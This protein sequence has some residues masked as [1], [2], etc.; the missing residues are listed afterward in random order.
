MV[1]QLLPPLTLQPVGAEGTV[2]S[3]PSASASDAVGEKEED[4]TLQEAYEGLL[5][6]FLGAVVPQLSFCPESPCQKDPGGA[7]SHLAACL[8]VVAPLDQE[9]EKPCGSPY[10]WEVLGEVADLRL[11]RVLL[12]H[13]QNSAWSEEASLPEV[14]ACAVETWNVGVERRL[15]ALS[16]G[17]MKMRLKGVVRPLVGADEIRG[18]NLTIGVG[19]EQAADPWK[20]TLRPHSGGGL[21]TWIPGHSGPWEGLV[22]GLPSPCAAVEGGHHSLEACESQ[23]E[24][25]RGD[26]GRG[27]SLC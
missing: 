19:V 10:P 13:H 16:V 27:R 6:S 7:H 15:P 3:Y 25:R 20:M 2:I 1:P 12:G 23:G 14:H 4:L 8:G 22:V 24:L 11:A 21:A 26:R 17:R 5:I 9:V 18:G